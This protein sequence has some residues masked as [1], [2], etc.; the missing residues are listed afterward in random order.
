M[1]FALVLDSSRVVLSLTGST[2]SLGPYLFQ[3]QDSR[4]YQDGRPLRLHPQVRRWR[5]VSSCRSQSSSCDPGSRRPLEKRALQESDVRPPSSPFETWDTRLINRLLVGLF[6][7]QLHHLSCSR[8]VVDQL[9]F[10][11]LA[12][13]S[14]S[15]F[16]V[17][18]ARSTT[19]DD[20][21]MTSVEVGKF[22]KVTS[23]ESAKR[24]RFL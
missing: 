6:R 23:R 7:S 21:L 4:C 22:S 13:R 12:L 5:T 19:T 2:P 14:L 3:T 15:L 9:P 11:R 17:R 8:Y 24:E 1:A 20:S 16:L 18:Q 10:R